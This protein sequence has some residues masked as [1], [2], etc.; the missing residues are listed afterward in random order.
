LP[1]AGSFYH[2]Q[3]SSLLFNA[4]KR[5]EDGQGW[6]LRATN[7]APAALDAWLDL[8]GLATVHRANLAERAL[9]EPLTGTPGA[10]GSYRY[11][12]P[13]RPHEIIT[14]AIQPH[15]EQDTR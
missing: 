15:T 9:S 2:L 4:C 6:L 3:P 11:S 13:V 1:A 14:L 7:T 5:R 8:P 12:F 10:D